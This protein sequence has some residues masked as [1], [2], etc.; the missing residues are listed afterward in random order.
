MKSILKSTTK[1]SRKLTL[2]FVLV[3][4]VSLIAAFAVGISDHLS[5]LTLCYISAISAILVFAHAW[6]KLNN[7]LVLL[8]VSLIA[9]LLFVILH[10]VF[11]ALSKMTADIIVLRLLLEFF[12]VV[13]FLTA[14]LVCPAG[15]LVGTVGG[16]ITVITYFKKKQTQDKSA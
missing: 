15:F 5:G 4:L 8:F 1:S 2:L 9:F 6:R 16:I 12:H 3:C 11:Y 7:F 13:F 10:N 14:T